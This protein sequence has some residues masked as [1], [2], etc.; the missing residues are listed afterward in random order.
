M[1]AGW[2]GHARRERDFRKL[3]VWLRALTRRRGE[4]RLV[5][6]WSLL[7]LLSRFVVLLVVII[8]VEKSV[9]RRSRSITGAGQSFALM[10]RALL[11]R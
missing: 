6:L 7:E 9:V 1:I 10:L 2:T 3:S 11:G 4:G 5:E 8:V